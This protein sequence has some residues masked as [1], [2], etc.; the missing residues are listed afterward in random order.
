M[1][2]TLKSPKCAAR[3]DKEMFKMNDPRNSI[4]DIHALLQWISL[5]FS[6]N[7]T[8]E[9][10][11]SIFRTLEEEN[12][13]GGRRFFCSST[14]YSPKWIAYNLQEKNFLNLEVQTATL[15]VSVIK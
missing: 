2:N 1:L 6:T 3:K 10:G 7:F 8:E 12:E 5:Y 13:D 14:I 15:T 4:C 11:N 9:H